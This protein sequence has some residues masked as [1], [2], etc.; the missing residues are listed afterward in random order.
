MVAGAPTVNAM[1]AIPV[2]LALVTRSVPAPTV[3]PAVQVPNAWP[4]ASVA[5]SALTV[6]SVEGKVLPLND[7]PE[8]GLPLR[9]VTVAV[10]LAVW[11]L[12]AVCV[13]GLT[14][15]LMVVGAPPSTRCWLCR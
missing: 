10:M 3:V 11:P 1:L 4:L 13:A 7:T 9:S 12:L 6:P 15:T 14:C 8:T 2:M 5:P